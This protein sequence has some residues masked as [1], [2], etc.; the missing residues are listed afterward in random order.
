MT[1]LATYI[2][3]VQRKRDLDAQSRALGEQI[4]AIEEELLDDWTEAG[5]SSETVNGYTVYLAHRDWA[6]PRDG[7][8]GRVVAALEALGMRDMVTY[9]TNSLSSW[10]KERG[11]QGEEVPPILAEAVDLTTKWSLNVRKKQGAKDNG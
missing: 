1:D 9:N 2:D 4:D 6:T 11:E 5:R 3:L 8:R 10:W 7:D